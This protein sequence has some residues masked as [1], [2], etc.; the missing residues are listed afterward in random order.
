ML[1]L[2]IIFYFLAIENGDFN[3]VVDAI[4]NGANVNITRGG[5]ALLFRELFIL[6]IRPNELSFI[7]IIELNNALENTEIV[8]ILLNHSV[9][10]NVVDDTSKTALMLGKC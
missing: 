2:R 6:I 4:N 3:G 9:E 1:F 7:L 10:L 8:Q 5:N